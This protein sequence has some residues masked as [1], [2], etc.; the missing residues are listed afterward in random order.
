MES[1][2]TP[3]FPQLEVASLRLADGGRLHDS[4]TPA[5]R[6]SLALQT[7]QSVAAVADRWAEAARAMK[8]RLEPGSR[9]APIPR[10]N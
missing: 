9:G 2:H 3:A 10:H 6:V 1:P 5:E 4:R 7:A 8:L